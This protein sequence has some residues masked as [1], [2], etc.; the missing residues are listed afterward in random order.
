MPWPQ[1]TA[2]P[3]HGETPPGAP[4]DLSVERDVGDTLENLFA[5]HGPERPV[6][7]WLFAL[8]LAGAIAALPLIEV[9]VS[10]R[11]SGWI[12]PAAERT[13]LRTPVSGHIARILARENEVVPLDAPLFVLSARDLEEALARN[14]AR[15]RESST[16]ISDLALLFDAWAGGPAPSDATLAVPA[17]QAEQAQLRTQLDSYGLAESKARTELERYAH[18]SAKGIATQQELDS[19]RYEVERLLAEQKL[20]IRQQVARWQA[21]MKERRAAFDDLLSEEKRLVVECERYV[22]RAPA[23][24]VVLGVS[25]LSVGGFVSAGQTLGT[26]SPEESLRAELLVAP[27]DIGFIHAGQKVRLQIDAFAYSQ[28]GMLD[29]V[30]KSVSGD[31]V[32]LGS[33]AGGQATGFRV[34]VAPHATELS[35]PNGVTGELRKGMSLTGRFI[36]ARRSLLDVLHQHLSDWLDPRAGAMPST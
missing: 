36:V 22:I 19:A 34:V 9:D 14:R 27:R 16:E 23:Q 11:A 32:A 29:G 18:L 3:F 15:Q 30:V 31:L 2:T 8:L 33:T 17:L 35:L 13:E 5:A 7:Y 28:W 24:G 21:R 20:L 1:T 6:L 25:F 26:I 12:R 10:V 4:F